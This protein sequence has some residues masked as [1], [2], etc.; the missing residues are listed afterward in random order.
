MS[1]RRVLAVDDDQS[2]LET[3]K[4]GLEILGFSVDT[5]ENEDGMWKALR[6]ARPDVILM[7]VS[8]PGMDGISLCRNL[9]GSPG[10]NDIP[11]IILTA[12]SDEKTFH[13]AMLF[14]ANDFLMKPFEI[15]E[16]FKKIE[17]CISKASQGKGADK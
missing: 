1:N 2:V 5:A 12:Y 11:I 7:D 15:S 4:T 6:G 17:D 10:M 13:D 8:M 9:R 3:L 14:G 16:V